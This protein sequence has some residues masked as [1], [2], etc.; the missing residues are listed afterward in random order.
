ML[1]FAMINVMC[2]ILLMWGW[3]NDHQIEALRGVA[4]MFEGDHVVKKI[5]LAPA[6]NEEDIDDGIDGGG[7]IEDIEDIKKIN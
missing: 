3:V 7:G 5:A 2:I 1:F 6:T 4:K